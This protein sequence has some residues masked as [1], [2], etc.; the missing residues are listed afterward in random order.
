M[1]DFLTNDTVSTLALAQAIA[2]GAYFIGDTGF[3]SDV[4]TVT[5][6]GLALA[7]KVNAAGG[8]DKLGDVIQENRILTLAAL[9]SAYI[10]FL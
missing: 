9:A 6:V 1:A 10:T 4:A 3:G 8:M 5:L 7:L 2:T